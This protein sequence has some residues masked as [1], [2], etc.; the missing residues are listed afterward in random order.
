M[1]EIRIEPT[2]YTVCGLPEDDMDASVWRITIARRAPG[3]K[4]WAIC[5]R[6]K[7][8]GKGVGWEYESSSSN[9]SDTYLRK[10]RWTLDE[11]TKIA[12][13]LYPTIVING[14]RVDNG[15]LVSDEHCIH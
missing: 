8:W 12:F 4:G 14:Y 10:H 11:A 1:S 2:E 9:R 5:H 3:P 7:T 13:D 6:G 15:R